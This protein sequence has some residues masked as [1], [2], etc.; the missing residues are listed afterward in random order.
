MSARQSQVADPVKI[1]I[2]QRWAISSTG[3][4]RLAPPVAPIRRA[5]WKGKTCLA[6]LRY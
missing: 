6:A 5:G 4:E 3:R 1:C 2:S